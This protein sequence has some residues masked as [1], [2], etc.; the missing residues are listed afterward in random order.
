MI[1]SDSNTKIVDPVALSLDAFKMFSLEQLSLQCPFLNATYLCRG[2]TLM[3]SFIKEDLKFKDLK[4][5]AS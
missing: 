5:S 3:I 2:Y 4:F 1:L